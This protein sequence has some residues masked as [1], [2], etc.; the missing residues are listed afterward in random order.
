MTVKDYQLL[1]IKFLL[2][3][4]QL[5]NFDHLFA[6]F[7]PSATA[8]GLNM[9]YDTLKKKMANPDLFKGA[10]IR[11]WARLIDVD[12]T[13]LQAFINKEVASRKEST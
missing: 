12:F 4:E 10:E 9:G 7:P 13:R 6:I 1:S 11:D 3:K 8:K 2:E 5:Q